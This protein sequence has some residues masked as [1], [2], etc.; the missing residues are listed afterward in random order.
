MGEQGIVMLR[1][2]IDAQG[3]PQKVDIQK[4]SGYDRLDQQAVDAVKRW[5]FVPGKDRGVPTPM[6]A[7]VPINFNLN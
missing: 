5:K 6:W 7:T 1:V 3:M 4:S 2:F